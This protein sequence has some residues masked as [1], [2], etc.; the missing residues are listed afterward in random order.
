MGK[1]KIN[2]ELKASEEVETAFKHFIPRFGNAAD[3]Y[4]LEVYEKIK[5]LLTQES[6]VGVTTKSTVE[7]TKLEIRLLW[8]LKNRT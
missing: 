5:K 6:E 7:I 8:L 1:K 2:L 4:I 3:K